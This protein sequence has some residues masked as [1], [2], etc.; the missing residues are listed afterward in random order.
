MRL[1]TE[2][3]LRTDFQ[4]DTSDFSGQCAKLDNHSIYSI[5]QIKDFTTSIDVNLFR[6]ITEGDGFSNLGDAPDLI[7]QIGSQFVDDPS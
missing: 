6:Q 1:T 4:C 3:A 2:L 7:G 5:L